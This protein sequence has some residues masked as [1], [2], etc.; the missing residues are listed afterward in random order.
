M[1]LVGNQRGGARDLAIHLMKEENDAVVVYEMR[2]FVGADLL[3]AFRES[4]AISRATRCQQHL[5]SLS[6]NPPPDES[7]EPEAF[8]E[9][10]DRVEDRLG[11]SGQPRAVVFHEKRGQDGLL[12]R[13]AH[14]VWCRIDTEA[15]R[16]IPLPHTRHKLQ[17]LARELYIEHDWRMPAG[18]VRH[19]DADPRNYSLAEWQQAKR[20]G[21]DPQHLKEMIQEAWAISDSQD[22]LGHAL[23]ERG[24]V[25]ARGDR[26]G[27]VAVDQDGEV[28]ALSRWVGIK[29]KRVREKVDAPDRLPD[30]ERATAAAASAIRDRVKTLHGEQLEA[31]LEE[32]AAFM[33][34]AGKMRE[35][36]SAAARELQDLQDARREREEADRAAR[37][38]R[39]WRGLLDR[40]TGRRRCSLERNNAE[41]EEAQRRDDRQRQDQRE[42][43]GLE[44]KALARRM[45]EA[46]AR[47][48]AIIEELER[49]LARLDALSPI[50]REREEAGTRH[51]AREQRSG[52]ERRRHRRRQRRD[53]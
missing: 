5:Y 9:A 22:A 8:M 13:H 47:R 24:L 34:E 42:R 19:G 11:L 17:E 45:A 41:A 49:D 14:A 36:Q 26:R 28:Y 37:L 30:V 40:I 15:M 52:E 53:P 50:E 4:Q 25:L 35:Q 16:A 51:S 27:V 6:L 43:H 44:Q 18:F 2:G 3:S 10:I 48:T 39:G 46:R 21:R 7:L 38:R 12:R 32:T 23:K 1:I 20:A 29:A 33:R 31:S